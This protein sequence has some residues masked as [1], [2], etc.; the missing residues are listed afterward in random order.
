[1]RVR[2]AVLISP[3]FLLVFLSSAAPAQDANFAI[4]M[5]AGATFA[6]G[7]LGVTTAVPV[8]D[9]GL[10][11]VESAPVFAIGALGPQL[12]LGARPQVRVSYA[13]PARVEGSWSICDPGLACPALLRPPLQADASRLELTAGVELPVPSLSGAVR[14]YVSAGA[15]IRRYGFSYERVVA[16]DAASLDRGSIS[17]TD[18]L[19]RVGA[20]AGIQLGRFEAS[21]EGGL[22]FSSF[23]S[24]TVPIDTESFIN[25]SATT[26]VGRDGVRE[27][28]LTAGLRRY[29]D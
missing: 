2:V 6:S 12:A 22:D 4:E 17:E 19:V 1:M 11:Q 9:F 10:Q 3:L 5:R 26:D 16:G 20:G 7:T 25:R 18:F 14:P 15:G 13:L 27:F 21:L 29:L 28:S 8:G 23:G 24:G